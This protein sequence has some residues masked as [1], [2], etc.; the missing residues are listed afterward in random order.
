MSRVRISS[1]QI[2]ARIILAKSGDTAPAACIPGAAPDE[3]GAA[4]CNTEPAGQELVLAA[5][6]TKSGICITKSAV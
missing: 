3:T 5:C 2:V 6:I 1:L 4:G